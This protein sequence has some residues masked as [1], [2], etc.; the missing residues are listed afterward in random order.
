ME[1]FPGDL[2]RTIDFYTQTLRFT[3][4]RREDNYA[5]LQRDG[6]FLGADASHPAQSLPVEARY[7][8]PPT[9]VEVVIEADDLRAERDFVVGSGRALDAD[10]KLQGWNSRDF[11]IVDPDGY[12]LRVTEHSKSRNGRGDLE[13][14][15]S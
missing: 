12:Y 11:R 15:K 9:G 1:I 4:L 6:I 14:E 5:Y 3:L 8:R 7:R 13:E 2:Q 10:V